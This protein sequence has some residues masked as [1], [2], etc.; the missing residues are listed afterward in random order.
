M[1]AWQQI[2]RD[3]SGKGQIRLIVQPA[4]AAFLGVHLRLPRQSL[5]DVGLLVALA[6]LMD[7]TFQYVTI[8]GASLLAALVVG[9]PVVLIPFAVARALTFTSNR[10]WTIPDPGPR[11]PQRM[12]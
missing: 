8:G 7:T 12:N 4:M 5:R 10:S 2:A 9:V 11:H 3:L 6:L 1:A